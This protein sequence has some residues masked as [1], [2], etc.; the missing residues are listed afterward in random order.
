M[1][2]VKKQIVVQK[3]IAIKIVNKKF[4]RKTNERFEKRLINEIHLLKIQINFIVFE[5]IFEKNFVQTVFR[6]FFDN[7]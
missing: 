5:Q 6:V 1:F 7:F 2:N 4:V 3:K